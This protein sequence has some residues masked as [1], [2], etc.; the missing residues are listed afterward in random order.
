MGTLVGPT[1]TLV[2]SWMR[3]KVTLSSLNFYNISDFLSSGSL[4]P[5][6]LMFVLQNQSQ[7]SSRLKVN[8]QNQQTTLYMSPFQLQIFSKNKNFF[9]YSTL[10]LLQTTLKC[11]NHFLKVTTN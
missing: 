7:L 8:H 10:F 1:L 9:Q 2:R 4:C 5:Y 6:Q 11:Q 3:F